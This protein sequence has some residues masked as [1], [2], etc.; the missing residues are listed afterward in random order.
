M[1]QIRNVISYIVHIFDMIK[2]KVS[3][4]R[5]FYLRKKLGYCD[6]SATILQPR[7]LRAPQKVFLYEHSSLSD[8]AIFVMN[9]KSS[10]G[11]FI[12]KKWAGAAQNLTVITDNHS[13]HPVIGHF[14]QQDSLTHELDKEEDV[15][16]E[17]DVWVGVNVT[18]MQGVTIGRGSIVGAGSVVRKNIP[19]YAIAVGNPARI[20]GFKFSPIEIIEHEKVLYSEAERISEE[21][22]VR[23][24]EKHFL[25]RMKEIKEYLK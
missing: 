12:M 16:I 22:L 20:V 10:E 15:V 23:N 18:I 7:S 9:P 2:E 4:N 25:S 17:E 11:R 6:Q 14:Y 3:Y 24:Y 13:A 8:G 19:P 5:I 1:K 21:V